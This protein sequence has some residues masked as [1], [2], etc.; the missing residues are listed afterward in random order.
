MGSLS[1]KLKSFFS[2][3]PKDFDKK[4]NYESTLKPND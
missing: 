2:K 3:G 4:P 1:N